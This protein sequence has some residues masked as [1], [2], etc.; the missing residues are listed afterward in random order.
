M[1]SKAGVAPL[2]GYLG[3]F[4]L[5]AAF[6]RFQG[7]QVLAEEPPKG[8]GPPVE[9]PYRLTLPKH[10]MVRAKING[11]GPF[12][13][14]LDT[15]AP[16]LFFTE[17][18]AAQAGVKQESDGWGVCK[19]LEL[20]GGLKIPNARARIDTPFQ[21]EGMNGMGLAGAQ[22]HGLMGYNILSRFR[23]TIDLAN[24]KMV[25]R[26][27]DW[28]PKSPFGIADKNAAASQGG[29][30]IIGGLI[31]GLGGA[32][33]RK[34]NPVLAPRGFAGVILQ[35]GDTPVVQ[36]VVPGGPAAKAGLRGGDKVLEI[37]DQVVP[38]KSTLAEKI[39]KAQ[40]GQELKVKFERNGETRECALILAEGV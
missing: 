26:A 22:I 36:G 35:E 5:L 28:E 10:L 32:L 33:G 37:N 13:F 11:K 1:R 34:A 23:I 27:L 8:V 31:K 12:N 17:E 3:V 19:D 15:G 24:D 9:V 18:V 7:S 4:A 14:I 38:R 20:E 39:S 40:K 21:L 2:A 6:T 25:W 29:L 16:S 30:E